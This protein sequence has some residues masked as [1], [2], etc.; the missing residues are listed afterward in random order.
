MT[1]VDLEAVERMLNEATQGEW[2]VGPVPKALRD[3]YDVRLTRGES[4]SYIAIP[5]NDARLIASA[6]TLIR[7][8]IEEVRG[9]RETIERLTTERDEALVM[10]EARRKCQVIAEDEI[11]RVRGERDEAYR[12][13]MR[14][15]FDLATEY[16][17]NVRELGIDWT[18]TENELERRMSIPRASAA[19]SDK[20]SEE[21]L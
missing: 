20:L 17:N 19:P 4:S 12:R 16:D 6:P 21:E 8:L 2:S 7:A 5:E 9:L 3:E 13:G 15:G 18:A 10:L 1:R 14:D 11:E